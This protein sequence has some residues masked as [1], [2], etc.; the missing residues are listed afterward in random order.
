[1]LNYI[2][3]RTIEIKVIPNAKRNA[4]K[5]GKVYLTAPAVEGKANRALIIFLAE[6]YD[7]KR[8]RIKII[9]GMK[10]RNKVIQIE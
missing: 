9:K 1:M 5:N 10:A 4:F 7:V 8:S 6:Y 2:M 3:P